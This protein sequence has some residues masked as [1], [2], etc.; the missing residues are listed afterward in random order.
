MI[1]WEGFPMEIRLAV[2]EEL[3]QDGC[4][5]ADF[6]TVSREWQKIIEP[7]NFSRI[8]LTPACLADFGQMVHRNRSLV[9]YIW[10][11]LELQEYDCTECDTRDPELYSLSNVDNTLIATAILNLFT[12][13]SV[14]K[15]GNSLLLD[16]SIY[17]LS[18]SKHWFKY[19]T[20]EPDVAFDMF[21]RNQHT[22]ASMTVRPTD[23]HHGWIAGS[24]NSIPSSDALEKT[25]SEIMGVGPFDDKEQEGQWWQQLPLVPA[26]TGLLLRQQSRRRWKPAALARM[27]ALLPGLQEIHYEPW[28]EWLDIHQKWTDQSLQHLF[29]SLSCS[30]L[31]RLVIFEN[32]DQTYSASY[33]GLGC[34]P[35]RIPSSSVSRALA[36][37]S[38]TLEHLS[39]SFMVEASHFF[40]ARELSWKWPNLTWL[41]L[42]SRLL[43]PQERSAELDNMLQAAAAAAMN[44]PNLETMEIWN[45]EKGLAMLFRYQRNN[46]GQPA[47]IICK[48]TWELTLR[49]LVIQ[50]WDSVSLEHCGQGNV[51][52]KELLDISDSIKSHGDAI[53]HL[54]LSKPVVRP[55]SLRQIQMKHTI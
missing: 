24:Q 14:W 29:E 51:I 40:K 18:D 55:V 17:S 49:P 22:V 35:M 41:A 16:I 33:K 36:N 43:V 9:R 20:F 2:L 52:I 48:G 50:A 13:L 6:A 1:S 7:H 44:M 3:M 31:Q 46:R 10:L 28:R 15:P 38:L 45:G 47:V 39:T 34:D 19:L 26:V 37:A 25:F 23:H 54:E 53:R 5:L 11:C 27:F 21:D 12:T 32:F 4:S 42:T 8:K 30:Q